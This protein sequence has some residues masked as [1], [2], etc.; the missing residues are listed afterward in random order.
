MAV[1]ARWPELPADFGQRCSGD[2][3]AI[4]VS[5]PQAQITGVHQMPDAMWLESH[6]NGTD[7]VHG[8]GVHAGKYDVHLNR[9][10]APG[11]VSLTSQDGIQYDKVRL[12]A[13]VHMWD[14]LMDAVLI[15]VQTVTPSHTRAISSDRRNPKDILQ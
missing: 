6:E 15:T 2:D 3:D 8:H 7:I 11:P 5:H 9:V 14:R 10:C 13:V 4:Q 12:P 1:S